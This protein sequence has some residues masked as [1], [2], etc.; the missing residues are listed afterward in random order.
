MLIQLGLLLLLTFAPGA[1]TSESTPAKAPAA[2]LGQKQSDQG[3][4]GDGKG[5]TAV[6]AKSPSEPRRSGGISDDYIIGAGDVLEI[7]VWKEPDVSVASIVVRPEGNITMPLLKDVAVAG[8]SPAQAE[9]LIATQLAKFI[10]DPTVTV[11]VVGINSKKVYILGAVKKEGPMPYTYR[12]TVMQAISEAGGLTDYAKRKKIYVLRNDHGR[13]FRI[14]F[15]YDAVIKG[16][17]MELNI[18][19]L[20][21]DTLVIPH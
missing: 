15:D 14:P 19:L 7:H 4:T 3:R 16:E 12:M 11:V 17:R 2:S 21:G 13:D 20:P 6:T 8:L 18:P 5:V 10:K 1:Q 9:H